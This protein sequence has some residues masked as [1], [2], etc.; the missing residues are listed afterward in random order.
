MYA[1]Q[2]AVISITSCR[3]TLEIDRFRLQIPEMTRSQ[4]VIT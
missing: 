3:I 1:M 4:P 2:R